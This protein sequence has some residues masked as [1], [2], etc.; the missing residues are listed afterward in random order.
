ML[1]VTDRLAV[2]VGGGAVA[3]RKVEGLLDAGATR[4]RVVA[5]EFHE[6]MPSAAAVERVP[7]RYRAAHLDGAGL[8]VAATDRPEV[9]DAVLKD[10]RGRGIL[11]SRVDEAEEGNADFTV[12]AKFVEG[13]VVVAVSAGSA[14]LAVTI[15]DGLRR[16]FDP[17]WRDM[18]AAMRELRPMIRGA[19]AMDG[20]RRREALRALAAADAMDVIR[21]DGP[22]GVKRWLAARFPELDR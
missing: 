19:K 7:E 17:A 11:V 1:D 16:A 6:R 15:R 2:V 22:A 9:N 8:V 4:V 21:K 18:A 12:P 5:P 13:S 14:A 20:Q 10:A 3:V